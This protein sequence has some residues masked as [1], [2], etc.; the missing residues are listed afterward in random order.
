MSEIESR[1]VQIV[2]EKK[3]CDPADVTLEARFIED[4]GFDSLDQVE[5]VMDFEQEFGIKVSDKEAETIT[6]VQRAVEFV[7]GRFGR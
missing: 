7:R 4:L 5:L 1:C 6:T 2:V 3:G